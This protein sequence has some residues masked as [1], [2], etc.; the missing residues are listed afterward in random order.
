MMTIIIES[1]HRLSVFPDVVSSRAMIHDQVEA[2]RGEARDLWV[3][4]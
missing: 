4:R 2:T 3:M 1:Y